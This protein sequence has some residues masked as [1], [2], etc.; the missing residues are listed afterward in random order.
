[1][2]W[3]NKEEIEILKSWKLQ[4]LS[5]RIFGIKNQKNRVLNAYELTF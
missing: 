4:D 3:N 2:S 1:M 5:L